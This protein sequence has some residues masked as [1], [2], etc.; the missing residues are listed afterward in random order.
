[1]KKK[2]FISVTLVILFTIGAVVLGWA[3]RPSHPEELQATVDGQYDTASQQLQNM[4]QLIKALQQFE[5]N[6]K[7]SEKLLANKGSIQTIASNPQSSE[8]H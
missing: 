5:S 3:F 4:E 2:L 1:M 8:V 7:E 6:V